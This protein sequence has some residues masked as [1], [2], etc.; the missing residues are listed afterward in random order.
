MLL[1]NRKL[2]ILFFLVFTIS[3]SN[4]SKL[5]K[6][7]NSNNLA[8]LSNIYIEEKKDRA[9]QIARIEL[10]KIINS[11]KNFSNNNFVKYNLSFDVKETISGNILSTSLNT[12]SV[13]VN[14]SLKDINNEEVFSDNFTVISSFG[15]VV[16]LY[17]REQA[18]K[19]TFEK[20]ALSSSSEIFLRLKNFL[21]LDSNLN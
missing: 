6:L 16:S 7:K 14:F 12:M 2:I 13:N 21:Y 9:H 8:L 5:I 17:G 19:Y 15:S 18:K 3:C 1:F 10:E 11:S 20:L 4:D